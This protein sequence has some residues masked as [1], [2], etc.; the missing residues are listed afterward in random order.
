[1]PKSRKSLKQPRSTAFARQNGRCYYC[2]Q[3]M[4]TK[5]LLS[6]ASKYNA[7]PSQVTHFQCTGEHL[8]AHQDGG[9]SA[10]KNIVAAC[11]YCN[12]QRHRRKVALSPKQ[13]KELIWRRMG[14][15]RWHNFRPDRNVLYNAKTLENNSVTINMN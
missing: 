13:H 3:P 4:W 5:D 1:M 10:Q 9:S 12:Q 2:N 14:Q 7:T 6:F 11:R 8:N 15:G